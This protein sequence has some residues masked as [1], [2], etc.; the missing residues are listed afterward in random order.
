MKK[1]IEA[2]GLDPNVSEAD[3]VAAV[4]SLQALAREKAVNAAAEA[5]I[6]A[7]TK[8]GLTRNVAI[9]AIANQKLEDARVAALKK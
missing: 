4:K 7:K 9:E 5:E 1:I 6:Q 2:L 3:V 8:A